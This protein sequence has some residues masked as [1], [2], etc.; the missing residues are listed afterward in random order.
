MRSLLDVLWVAW[1]AVRSRPLR[2]VLMAIGPLLGVAVIVS[3]FGVMESASGD[4]RAALR[5]LGRDLALVTA[6][7]DTLMSV[8]ARDRI[9]SVPTVE[10]VAGIAPVGGVTAR[11]TNLERSDRGQIAFA[12]FRID[13]ELTRVVETSLAW[14]RPLLPHDEEAA[15]GAAILGSEVASRIAF[16]PEELTTVYLD[17]QPFGIVGALESS[18]LAPEL[19][20]AI[21]ISHASAQRLTRTVSGYSHF[22]VRTHEDVASVTA[23]VLPTAVSLGAPGQSPTVTLPADL[24]AAQVAIDRTLAGAV[25]GL[26]VLAMLV[27]GFGITNVML[28]SVL[29]RQKE[30]GVRRALGH[31]RLSIGAQFL[32]EAT[33][34]GAIGAVVGG[35]IAMAFINLF[36][37][38]RGWVTILNPQ[39]T[40]AAVA[41]AIAIT[42]LA[43]LYP[44]TR[45][46]RLQPL[47]ALRGE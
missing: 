1:S 21:L 36:A 11:S 38:T 13:P 35:A 4:V 33:V 22:Y 45:A 31:S 34:I 17:E 32:I 20:Q 30:I 39:L 42:V 40:L 16:D 46:M 19:D 44:A 37:K 2:A 10:G 6:P 8:E 23:E 9:A 24:L 47:E 25:I 15:T 14:G 26:G 3:A 29:E 28:I 5:D 27:G 12:V 43:A 18:L 41:G 7:G